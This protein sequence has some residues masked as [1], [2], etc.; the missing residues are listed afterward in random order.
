MVGKTSWGDKMWST[1]CWKWQSSTLCALWND[2]TTVLQIFVAFN[3]WKQNFFLPNYTLLIDRIAVRI[4]LTAC[5]TKCE[6]TQRYSAQGENVNIINFTFHFSP[7]R[8]LIT[9]TDLARGFIVSQFLNWVSF[10]CNNCPFWNEVV[11]ACVNEITSDERSERL[12][13]NY[14]AWREILQHDGKVCDWVATE[15]SLKYE[16][17]N[18]CLMSEIQSRVSNRQTMCRAACEYISL[19]KWYNSSTCGPVLKT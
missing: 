2:T 10:F 11:F 17:Y 8:A 14:K 7:W 13:N 12:S 5:T 18:Q 3:T 19:Y 1:T 15:I 16:N 4:S 6:T 9:L